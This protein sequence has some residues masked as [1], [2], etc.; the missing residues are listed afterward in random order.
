MRENQG[1]SERNVQTEGTWLD[2]GK[3]IIFR[4]K[5]VVDVIYTTIRASLHTYI[6]TLTD[7]CTN[8]D[9]PVCMC[10]TEAQLAF[11]QIVS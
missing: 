8:I 9:I 4:N 10:V 1:D 6:S 11:G 7:K 5:V 2:N 3:I